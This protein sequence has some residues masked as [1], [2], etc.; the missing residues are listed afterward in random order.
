[1]RDREATFVL[2][3]ISTFHLHGFQALQDSE[4]GDEAEAAA[5]CR[6]VL[7]GACMGALIE[8]E[9]SIASWAQSELPASAVH[10]METVLSQFKDR[11]KAGPTFEEGMHMICI[12]SC[13][14]E[15]SAVSTR[16]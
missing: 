12:M 16:T 11:Y 4:A 13:G 8:T 2:D 7:Q 9:A 3:L 5:L 14:P 15:V 10:K 6:E 1:M